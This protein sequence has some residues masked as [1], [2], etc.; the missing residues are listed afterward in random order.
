MKNKRPALVVILVLAVIAVSS[1]AHAWCLM[2]GKVYRI[3]QRTSYAYIYL[4]PLTG[5]PQP[6]GFVIRYYTT[7]QG[8][9]ST[10]SDAQSHNDTVRIYGGSSTSRCPAT[11][12][13]R[14]GGAI[15]SF[16]KYNGM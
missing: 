2:M 15:Y 7:N 4:A 11:G 3:Y 10:L 9:I 1:S 12:S 6:Y 16:Y 14:Y 13:S 5:A 8:F